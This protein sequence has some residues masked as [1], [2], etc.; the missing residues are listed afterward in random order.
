MRETIEDGKGSFTQGDALE[1][2]WRTFLKA[3]LVILS[4]PSTPVYYQSPVLGTEED[5]Y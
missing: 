2:S 1:R 4:T 3:P 5:Y